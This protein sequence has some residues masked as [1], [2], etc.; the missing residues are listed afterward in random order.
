MFSI[1]RIFSVQRSAAASDQSKI[2]ACRAKA[3][4]ALIHSE[5]PMAVQRAL[6][7][8]S[9]VCAGLVLAGATAAADG[10]AKGPPS[11]PY[12]Y[13]PQ[14]I[15][16]DYNWSGIYVG[17]HAGGATAS[18]DWTF[19]NPTEGFSQSQTSFAGGAQIGAQKQWG[20]AVLG[21]EVSYTWSDLC[22]SSASAAAPG[23]SRSSKLNNLL[24]VTGRVGATY[25]NMLAI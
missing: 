9:M 17:G 13:E 18:W 7:T 1:Q 4:K 8:A 22:T 21:V 3:I 25:E 6:L 19:T 10:P 5:A 20:H 12:A 24:M 2:N 23:E 16:T 11:D 14:Y 15:A